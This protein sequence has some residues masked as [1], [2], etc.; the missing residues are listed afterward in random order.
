M[1]NNIITLEQNIFKAHDAEH[2]DVV[3]L[4]DFN[5]TE[6]LIE[7]FL[8]AAGDS[9]GIA[10]AFGRKCVL[11][12]IAVASDTL[13]L[14]IQ[15]TS[16]RNSKGGRAVLRDRILCSSR[17]SKLAF[18]MDRISTALYHDH[19]LHIA[20]AIDLQSILVKIKSRQAP[21]TVTSIL[22]GER[23]LNKPEVLDLFIGERS[24]S[25]KVTDVAL[26]A[27]TSGRARH[28]QGIPAALR[29]D[30]AKLNKEVPFFFILHVWL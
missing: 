15:M 24:S 29:I 10:A 13:I 28:H 30:T 12:A 14:Y 6:S 2:L 7:D 17:I 5:I 19:R 26:R 1:Q 27:W 21:D 22:G 16:I 23:L 25:S 11:S 4:Q 20:H 18:D 3:V 8:L 9:V